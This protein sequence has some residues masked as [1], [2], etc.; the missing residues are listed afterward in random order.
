MMHNAPKIRV[1]DGEMVLHE[2][3]CHISTNTA[4]QSKA[5][6]FLPANEALNCI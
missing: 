4:L 1:G 5:E 3:K 2:G 6:S